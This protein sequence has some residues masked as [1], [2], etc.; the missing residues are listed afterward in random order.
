MPFLWEQHGGNNHGTVF[1]CLQ[2]VCSILTLSMFYTCSHLDYHLF[3]CLIFIYINIYIIVICLM[4]LY[5]YCMKVW[6]LSFLSLNLETFTLFT[7]IVI[8][9]VY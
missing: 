8:Y 6:L 1:N 3:N 7:I 9:I 2:A 5:M 4:N